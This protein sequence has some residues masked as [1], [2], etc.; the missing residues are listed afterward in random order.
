MRRIFHLYR[1]KRA[2]YVAL[3]AVCFGASFFAA[4]YTR[5][6]NIGWSLPYPMHPDERNMADAITRL[7]CP[8]PASFLPAFIEGLRLLPSQ[9]FFDVLTTPT[10]VAPPTTLTRCLYPHF[11]AY[12]Q[13]TLY[14]GKAVALLMAFGMPDH[15][16]FGGVVTFIHA[17]LALRL[18]SAVSSLITLIVAMRILTRLGVVSHL[19]RLFAVFLLIFSP[20]AIQFAHFG[21]TESILTLLMLLLVDRL[22]LTLQRQKI[23]WRDILFCSSVVGV[24]AGTK[25]SALIT[26]GLIGFVCVY[27]FVNGVARART[28]LTQRAIV[29]ATK[30]LTALVISVVLIVVFFILTSPFNVISFKD[31]RGA[32]Q[33]ESDVGTGRYVAFYTKQFLM[34][35]PI[36]FHARRVLPYAL[37][38]GVWVAAVAGFFFLPR[39]SELNFLRFAVL[40]VAIPNMFFYTKWTRFLAPVY[41]LLVLFAALWLLRLFSAARVL[42]C[43]G[44]KAWIYRVGC[45]LIFALCVAPGVAMTSVYAQR[46]VRFV[47]SDWIFANTP[48]TPRPYILSETANVIDLP[49]RDPSM[50]SKRLAGLP[51]HEFVSFDF[52]HVDDNEMLQSQLAKHIAQATHIYVPSRRVFYNFTC[53]SEQDGKLVRDRHSAAKCA[54][55]RER[56]P[57]LDAYYAGLFSGQL[58]FRKVAEFT[59][60]PRLHVFGHTFWE[61]PDESAE[62]TFSVFDHPVVRIYERVR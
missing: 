23:G 28:S 5:F 12:G 16:W 47:A 10:A 9:M 18:I 49:I 45:V 1:R 33:Y 38:W 20:V 53:R 24:S 30:P 4:L 48:P 6:V 52:Y 17:T 60:F 46:D 29:S 31:F 58:G 62:E 44:R 40:L 35:T 3:V 2:S 51:P 37:G 11:F 43:H 61:F 19:S 14:L 59:S 42:L 57:T 54:Y 36:I 15:P 39:S 13:F 22:I 27:F 41:P 21:T 50:S 55:L 7:A 34:E 32:M 25:L 26:L 56:Y 8:D